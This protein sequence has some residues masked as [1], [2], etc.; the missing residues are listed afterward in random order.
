V[1][2]LTRGFESHSLRQ[3]FTA[4]PKGLAEIA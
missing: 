4:G 3:K 1:G 2:Q